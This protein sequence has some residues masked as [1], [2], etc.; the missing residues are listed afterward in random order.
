MKV[1]L[2]REGCA[3]IFSL[4]SA[5]FFQVSGRNKKLKFKMDH[6]SVF[7]EIDKIIAGQVIFII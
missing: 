7:H 4:Y 3:R 6:P 5:H 1:F 2:R